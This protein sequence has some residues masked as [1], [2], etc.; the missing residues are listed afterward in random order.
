MLRIDILSSGVT[1][2]NI[3]AVALAL[4][5]SVIGI[6]SI[7]DGL[8]MV[9]PNMVLFML[10]AKYGFDLIAGP[11]FPGLIVMV[12][13]ILTIAWLLSDVNVK[14]WPSALVGSLCSDIPVTSKVFPSTTSENI[15]IRISIYKFSVKLVSIGLVVCGVSV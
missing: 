12:Y 1:A 4:F 10:V 13:P 3:T 15:S 9:L 5:P 6:L 2:S 14:Y 11:P 7:P 8:L